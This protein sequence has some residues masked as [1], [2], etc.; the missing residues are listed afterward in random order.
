MAS[1]TMAK[2]CNP[3][4][5]SKSS[6][7]GWGCEQDKGQLKEKGSLNEPPSRGPQSREEGHNENHAK[8]NESHCHC[9]DLKPVHVN[10]LYLYSPIIEN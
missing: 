7:K 5:S 8:K 10:R 9:A 3:A 2:F 6:D 4:A 1:S